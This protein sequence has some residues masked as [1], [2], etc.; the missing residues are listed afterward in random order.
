MIDR[1]WVGVRQ[2]SSR[3]SRPKCKPCAA[4]CHGTEPLAALL[5][6]ACAAVSCAVT[7]AQ[8]IEPAQPDPI[9]DRLLP[10]G[11]VSLW[12][13]RAA[14]AWTEALPVGNGSLGAM[15]FGGAKQEHLQ[16]NIDSLWAGPPV[17]TQQPHAAEAI[18]K[19]RDLY[20]SGHA[21]EAEDLLQQEVLAR[22]DSPRSYQTLGDVHLTLEATGQVEHYRRSL[23]LRHGLAHTAFM[24]GESAYHRQVFAS[25]PDQII[26]MNLRTTDPEGMAGTLTIDRPTDF[27]YLRIDENTIAISGQATQ[28][29]THPGT[30]YAAVVRF[31]SQK[32]TAE[33][34]VRSDDT[35]LRYAGIKSG[36]VLI[37]AATDYNPD[38]PMHPKDDDLIE[39]CLVRLNLAQA[40]NPRML[41]SSHIRDYARLFG[42]VAIDLGDGALQL[43]TDKRLARAAAGQA[44]PVLD[45]LYF[46]FGR[47]L[48]IS[49]SRPGSL[50]ANLQGIWN[51]HINAPWNSDYHLNINLQMNYWPAEVTNLSQ[52]AEPLFDYIEGLVPDGRKTARALGANEG[53]AAG[54]GSDVW[55]WTTPTGQVEWGMWVMGGAWATQHFME[56]YRFTLN[57]AFLKERAYPILRSTA[58]FLLDWLVVDPREGPTQGK[59]VSGLTISPENAYRNDEGDVLH[60]AMGPA[61]DQQIAWE[62]LSNFLEAA[63]VLGIEDDMTDRAQKALGNLAPTRIGPDGR[64]LEWDKPYDEPWPGHRHL[65]PLFG[66]YP[67]RQFTEECTPELVAACRKFLAYRLSHGSGHTGWSKAWI[68]NLYARLGDGNEAYH[69]FQELLANST[70]PNLFDTHPP[71][72]IDGNFGATAAVAEML[73]QSHEGT[74]DTPTIRL[75][76][77]LP[78]AWASGSVQGLRARGR[79]EI[80]I[81]W[82]NHSLVAAELR[83]LAGS[84]CR[85]WSP[86]PANVYLKNSKLIASTD[87]QGYATIDTSIGSVYRIVPT[88]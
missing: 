9:A 39:T 51:D 8:P 38:D 49:S 28:N 32:A 31:V 59:L 37:A 6:L 80:D 79:F 78:D 64:I 17:P 19:A 25:Y 69:H 44:D 15:V 20:C 72:Q 61:M 40:K 63:R 66:L 57:K 62:T 3:W 14:D 52:C 83:S 4:G 85:I 46:Q 1:L 26:V 34:S 58:A 76:P 87:E 36:S 43:P 29:G 81:V 54:H 82:E 2:W 33:H 41:L 88:R 5:V 13:E 70:L 12:Y 77:A 45:A 18:A 48:L 47:Y 22:D 42:R 50:P 60:V 75:L 24:I 68:L 7:H 16:L 84:R 86:V 21:K 55:H 27:A 30:R 11:D 65:S 53:W 67:G 73:L 56:H 74:L 35:G 71:F 10:V 23:D